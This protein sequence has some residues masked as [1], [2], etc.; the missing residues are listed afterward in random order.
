MKTPKIFLFVLPALVIATSFLNCSQ[1]F[2]PDSS[3]GSDYNP[4]TN[5]GAGSTS[6]TCST[7]SGV[8]ANFP[9][10]IYFN[11]SVDGVTLTL[12]QQNY[13]DH[14]INGL[15][16]RGGWGGSTHIFQ[17]DFSLD[18]FD[19]SGSNTYSVNSSDPSW[20]DSD[21]VTSVPAPPS[22]SSAG[23][24][25]ST[26]PACDGGDCHYMAL[27]KTQRKLFEVYGANVS[28]SSLT[29]LSTGTIAVWPFDKVWTDSLRGDVC[30]S[31]D[32]AGLSIGS[33]LF[34]ADEIHKGE[35]NHAI[36]FILPNSRIANKTYVRPASHTTGGASWAPAPTNDL[37][38]T[39]LADPTL[40]PGIPYGTRLRLK[41][42]YDIS[43]LSASAQV[44][45][46]ALK[47]YGM[48]LA[49][50]GNIALTAQSDAHTSAKY[51]SLGFDSHSLSA[52]HVTDFEVVPPDA[53]SA[54]SAG[55]SFLPTV[56]GP[57]I[58]VQGLDCEPNF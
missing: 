14:L 30:T 17:I 37:T 36:R 39:P 10:S 54:F 51:A 40:E 56:I 15:V 29:N 21:A 32:A 24:E 44:V 33:M 57:M 58:K 55:A 27:D 38:G 47:K 28:G 26:G 22:G 49:D 11:Q 19:V 20:T 18:V 35:I 5:L 34:S 42:S 9:C 7:S 41:A 13:S 45:A 31:A 50:G 52:L 23:F 1:N 48:I 53:P 43:G 2:L 8:A 6:V 3:G 46:K 12:A 25:S 16:A 4:G